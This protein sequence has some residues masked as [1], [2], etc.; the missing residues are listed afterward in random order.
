MH[1]VARL[2]T[3]LATLAVAGT[4]FAQSLSSSS[5]GSQSS[6]TGINIVSEP[7]SLPLVV[8]GAVGVVAVVRYLKGKNKK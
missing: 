4:A 1:L 8:L 5:A 2:S 3:A 7:G 6:S